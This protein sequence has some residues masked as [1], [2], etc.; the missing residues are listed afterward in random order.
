M[1]KKLTNYQIRKLTD[2]AL[3]NCETYLNPSEMKKTLREMMD[4]MAV[5]NEERPAVLSFKGQE[6]AAEEIVLEPIQQREE[7]KPPRFFSPCV[8]NSA[9]LC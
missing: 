6:E 2:Y 4:M 5:L 1:N 3:E 9:S 8:S 7:K